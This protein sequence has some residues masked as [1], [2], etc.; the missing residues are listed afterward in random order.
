MNAGAIFSTL[1]Y[2]M[3]EHIADEHMFS[4]P[5]SIELGCLDAPVHMPSGACKKFEH[6][7]GSFPAQQS[8]CRDLLDAYDA[9]DRSAVHT[10]CASVPK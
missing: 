4:L 5:V 6:I 9:T 3:R 1:N 10:D 7:G 8:L 2:D